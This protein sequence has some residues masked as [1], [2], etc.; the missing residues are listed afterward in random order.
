MIA[1][2]ADDVTTRDVRIDLAAK[3]GPSRA[4]D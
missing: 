3:A 2:W 4:I 1:F